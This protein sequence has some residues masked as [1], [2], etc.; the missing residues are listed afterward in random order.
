M[1]DE[2]SMFESESFSMEFVRLDCCQIVS[3]LVIFVFDT[4][5]R[6]WD[7]PNCLLTQF[8]NSSITSDPEVP[9]QGF[10]NV[11]FWANSCVFQQ[12]SRQ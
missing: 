3:I 12:N 10:E 9:F 6:L 1:Y 2:V 7:Y 8:L 5:E 11:L 4:W